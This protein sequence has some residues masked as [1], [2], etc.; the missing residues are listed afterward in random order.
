[1]DWRGCDKKGANLTDA[2]LHYAN[3]ED[4]NPRSATQKNTILQGAK[5]GKADLGGAD[6]WG[7]DLRV[8]N[9]QGADLRGAI[10]LFA[11]LEYASLEGARLEGANLEAP[12]WRLPRGQTTA[13]LDVKGFPFKATG[14]QPIELG[15][16][17]AFPEWQPADEKGNGAQLLPPMRD[18]EPARLHDQIVETKETK[19]PPRYS[20]GT[21][22]EAMQ[23][24]WQFV[25]D[26]ILRD[27][28]Q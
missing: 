21:L 12:L 1:V 26:E 10:L 5:L 17:A 4:A 22:I 19:P 23:N 6:L 14:R 18:G 27:R 8:A 16:R 11:H 24:A 2:N 25:D 28:L 13:T 7:A 3:L 20:E 15:W 9:L